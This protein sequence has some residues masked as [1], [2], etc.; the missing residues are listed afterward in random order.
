[1]R[2]QLFS[3]LL[4]FLL[5]SFGWLANSYSADDCVCE[6]ITCG[7]CEIEVE[8]KFYTLKCGD[9]NRV[10][11]CKKPVCSPMDKKDC[12]V[13]A[14]SSE[15]KVIKTDKVETKES[16]LE[17]VQTQVGVM[18]VA[19]GTGMVIRNNKTLNA[20]IGL[21]VFMKDY[22]E[23]GSDG[24]IK[25]KFI[26]DNIMNL[27]PNSK[28]T[29]EQMVFDPAKGNNKTMLNL[30]YGKVRSTVKQS[31]NGEN[32]YHVKTP[33]AIAGV[34]GTDFVTSFLENESE[35]K[36]ETK[37]ETISGLVELNDANKKQQVKISAGTYASFIVAKNE[38]SVFNE[39][40]VSGFVARGYLTPVFKMTAEE[41]KKLEI[42]TN[43][44]QLDSS[45]DKVE[46]AKKSSDGDNICK[47]PSGDFNQCLWKC[48]NN[49]GG[50]KKCRTDIPNVNCVRRRCNAN[51]K[52]AEETRL[53][54][55]FHELCDP[56][57]AIVKS[58]DY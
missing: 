55:S 23:T 45:T 3:N 18:V 32:Y 9:N 43:F 6:V 50:E 14:P 47:N 31:Y 24:K 29:I 25:V 42:T 34:R 40:D 36:V 30:I 58:C 2:K 15:T 49:P 38:G 27:T 21:K 7:E 4:A 51:G 35:K 33:T 10:K 19:Q 28:I 54:A 57:K 26:D 5:V 12:K 17:E 52:W 44:N 53:P 56:S 41:L 1:M 46:L 16:E 48:E 20:K 39:N 8:I 37:V 22:I 13:G 11:S